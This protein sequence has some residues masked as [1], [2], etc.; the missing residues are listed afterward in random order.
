M[1]AIWPHINKHGIKFWTGIGWMPDGKLLWNYVRQFRNTAVITAV[2]AYAES[3]YPKRGKNIWINNNLGADVT[4]FIGR[5]KDKIRHVKPG[6]ILIDDYERTVWEWRA[7]GGIGII[8][9]SADDTIAKL[10][11]L[12]K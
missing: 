9:K 3:R 4:R 5:R 10:K 1:A 11:R 8:H 12:V 7:N 6:Y 2:P